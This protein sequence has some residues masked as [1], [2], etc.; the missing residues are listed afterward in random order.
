M[1]DKTLLLSTLDSQFQSDYIPILKAHL[2]LLGFALDELANLESV[3]NLLGDALDGSLFEAKWDELESIMAGR[4][5]SSLLSDNAVALSTQLEY[6]SNVALSNHEA[7]NA[8]NSVSLPE[9]VLSEVKFTQPVD[10]PPCDY[11]L[12]ED[13]PNSYGKI[14]K[15][16][17]WFK[18]NTLQNSMELVHNSGTRIRV[19]RAGNVTEYIKGSK[20]TIIEGDYS[21]EVRGSQDLIIHKDYYHHVRGAAE[22]LC[23]TTFT[24]TILAD[25]IVSVSG[26]TTHN[27][28]LTYDLTVGADA[29]YNIGGSFN[30]ISTGVDLT[31][32]TTI[33]MN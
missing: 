21:L 20:K 4:V 29:N 26:K 14:D 16:N 30:K 28:D 7:F 27:L 9:P 17:S 15:S 19:D 23:D 11:S 3:F 24:Q 5:S 13:Y 22:V 6:E 10:Q 2:E 32:A 33:M 12:E 25:S 31:D 18:V 1:L 8:T